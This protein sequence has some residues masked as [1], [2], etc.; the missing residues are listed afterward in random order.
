MEKTFCDDFGNTARINEIVTLPYK[1][2]KRK[3][4]CY[5]LSITADYNDDFLYHVSVYE[6]EEDAKNA[7]KAFSCNTWKEVKQ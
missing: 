5:K 3:Q 4:K 6:T 1:G 7:L 2:A